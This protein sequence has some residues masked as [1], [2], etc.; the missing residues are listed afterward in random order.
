MKSDTNTRSAWK[1]YFFS[2]IIALAVSYGVIHFNKQEVKESTGV[3]VVESVPGA[4]ALYTRDNEGNIK[5]LDF[6]ETSKNFLDAV[7]NIKSTQT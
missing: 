4:Q 2:A 1:V 6:T 5:T 7:V 3:T